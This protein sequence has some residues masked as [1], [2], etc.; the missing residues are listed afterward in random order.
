M[1]Q[2]SARITYTMRVRFFPHKFAL[3][4]LAALLPLSIPAQQPRKE[5]LLNGLK[6]LMFADS[7]TDKVW[8]RIRIHS[9]SAFDPQGKEGLMTVLANNFFPTDAA[10][11]YFRDELGGSL[12]IRANYD[13]IEIGAS[14]KAD[15]FIPMMETLS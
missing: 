12:D 4:M 15:S 6:V 11:D 9:G 10:K 7:S 2:S 5:S 13:Y 1:E 8:V 3:L 14:A